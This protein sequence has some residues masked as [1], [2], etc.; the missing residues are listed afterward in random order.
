MASLLQMCSPLIHSNV[1]VKTIQRPQSFTCTILAKTTPSD[2]SPVVP[3]R[4]AKYQ[5]SLWD[6]HNLLSVENKYTN[7]KSVRERDLLKENVRKMLNDESTTHTEQLKLIDDLQ[8]TRS[9]LPF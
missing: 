1:I 9:F 4:S 2:E 3:R 8:K 5:P 6:H 7:H